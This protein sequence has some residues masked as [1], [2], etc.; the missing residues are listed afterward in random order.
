[1]TSAII[2]QSQRTAAKVAGWSF[3]VT[4][5]IVVVS[6]YGLLNPLIVRGNVAETARNLVAHET[7]LRIT[8][9]CF[10]IY[11]LGVFVLLAALYVILKS[12]N[13]GLALVGAIFRFT[14]ALLWLL[15]ALNLLS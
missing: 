3:L 1:M 9:V 11:S 12:V 5:V 6:N 15:T 13:S 8:V 7:R 14:F 4:M 10:L 2:T